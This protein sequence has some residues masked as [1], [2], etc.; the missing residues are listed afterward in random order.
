MLQ[1][2]HIQDAQQLDKSTQLLL[3]GNDLAS[4]SRLQGLTALTELH[5]CGQRQPVCLDEQC[6][7]GLPALRV[8]NPLLGH[9]ARQSDDMF[10][11]LQDNHIQDAQQL[12]GLTRLRR[13]LLEGN[14]LASLSGLQG[15]TALTELRMCRQ[16]QPVSLDEP[17]MSGLPA[18]RVFCA[19]A[20]QLTSIIA[21]C[22]LTS[23]ERLDVSEN[24][25][26]TTA[27]IPHS[28]RICNTSAL[29]ACRVWSYTR[30][31]SLVLQVVI[32]QGALGI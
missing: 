24:R 14:D 8:L 11:V 32:A 17:C 10:C 20:C 27:H 29:G 5:I 21:L 1:D 18:L 19:S 13:L 15:L 16:R 9:A 7:T 31:D 28:Q 30:P 6:T 3:E 2:S 23:L 12:N 26:D 22:S 25:C 4:L